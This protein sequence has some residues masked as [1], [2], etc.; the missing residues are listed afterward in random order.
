MAQGSQRIAADRADINTRTQLGTFEHATGVA[1]VRA[2]RP[3]Q[4]PP[5]GLAMPAAAVN[6]VYYFGDTVERLELF[7]AV[8]PV[9]GDLHHPLTA[10]YRST[11]LLQVESLLAADRLR[12]FFLFEQLITLRI[13]L[14]ALRTVDPTLGSFLNLHVNTR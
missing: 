8:V 6:D 2:P 7:D 13:P 4:A 11:V 10:V 3:R 12:P 5:G 1:S 14:E 9:E